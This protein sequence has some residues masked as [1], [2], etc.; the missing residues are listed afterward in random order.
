MFHHRHHPSIFRVMGYTM[1]DIEREQDMLYVKNWCS[2][3]HFYPSE[4]G[5]ERD[6]C[7]SRE[8]PYVLICIKDRWK[9]H[10][11]GFPFGV[12]HREDKESEYKRRAQLCLCPLSVAFKKSCC[13]TYSFPTFT[14]FFVLRKRIRY[15]FPVPRKLLSCSSQGKWPFAL[16]I[17]LWK[18]NLFTEQQEED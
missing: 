10:L 15:F 14:F 9:S 17:T 1:V 16:Q 8:D 11:F 6:G 13:L 3:P 5:R 7:E 18:E 2:F 12:S 4:G